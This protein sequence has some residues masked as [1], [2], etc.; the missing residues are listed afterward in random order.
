MKIIVQKRRGWGGHGDL[1][2]SLITRF[3][4]QAMSKYDEKDAAEDT[5]SSSSQV[6]EA[7]HQA[8]DD[9]ESLVERIVTKTIEGGVSAVRSLFGLDDDDD[10]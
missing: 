8:R 6:S 10:E 3:R 9:D 7:W 4:R 2:S 1:F 5:D